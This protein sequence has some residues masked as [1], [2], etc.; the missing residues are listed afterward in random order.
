MTCK[1]QLRLQRDLGVTKIFVIGDDR[2]KQRECFLNLCQHAEQTAVGGWDKKKTAKNPQ[3]KCFLSA[4]LHPWKQSGHNR[5]LKH[6]FPIVGGVL[7]RDHLW[8]CR[9][10]QMLICAVVKLVNRKSL[11]RHDDAKH[12]RRNGVSRVSEPHCNIYFFRLSLSPPPF[13]FRV[14]SNESLSFRLESCYDLR[15]R[16][17]I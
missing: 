4:A 10:L 17:R 7:F 8:R 13:F 11:R 12:L 9:A 15:S 2:T 5:E 16:Y 3:N 6:P 14:K 1:V